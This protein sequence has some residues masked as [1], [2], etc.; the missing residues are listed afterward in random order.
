MDFEP[1]KNE[2]R[3][4]V[5][6]EFQRIHKAHNDGIQ[7]G[8]FWT[9]VKTDAKRAKANKTRAK[10]AKTE[11]VKTN[12]PK[13]KKVKVQNWRTRFGTTTKVNETAKSMF[14]L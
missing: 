6:I 1:G 10:K 14:M 9:V 2:T 13:A 11:K 7:G 8:W 4:S 5:K 3:K 12:T